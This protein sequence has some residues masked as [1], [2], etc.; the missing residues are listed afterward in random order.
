MATPFQILNSIWA[1]LHEQPNHRLASSV[2]PRAS[3]MHS[4]KSIFQNPQRLHSTS[5]IA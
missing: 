2:E 3:G 1:M 5:A 4:L